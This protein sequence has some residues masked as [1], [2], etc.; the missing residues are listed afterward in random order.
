MTAAVVRFIIV[1]RDSLLCISN[2]VLNKLASWKPQESVND[3]E[4]E[5]D[6]SAA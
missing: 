2:V 4:I 5:F 6:T 3:S 1:L